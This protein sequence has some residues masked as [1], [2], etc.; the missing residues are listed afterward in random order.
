M[1][2]SCN[3]V[4]RDYENS[5]PASSFSKVVDETPVVVIDGSV[6][7]YHWWNGEDG[8]ERRSTNSKA[9]ITQSG[10]SRYENEGWQVRKCNKI[11]NSLCGVGG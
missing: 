5:N 11:S 8:D 4:H 9:F 6:C 2:Y 3:A 1:L 7:I 10:D